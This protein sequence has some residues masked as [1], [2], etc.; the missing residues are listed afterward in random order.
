VRRRVFEAVLRPLLGAYLPAA[1][2]PEHLELRDAF[3]VRYSAAPGEQAGLVPH[4]DGSV[5]SFNVLLNEPAD[6]DGGGTHFEASGRTV[7]PPRGGAVGHS[8]QVRHSGVPITRGERYLLVG[9]VGVATRR[10][11]ADAADA[12]ARDA[13]LKFGDGAWARAETCRPVLL[14][15]DD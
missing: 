3:Y 6:F 13:Y 2:L 11:A 14:G 8:G 5:F 1:F 10:Y 12:A 4:T 9:F 7:R 15:D